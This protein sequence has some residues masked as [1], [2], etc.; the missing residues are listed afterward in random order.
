MSEITVGSVGVEVVPD[1]RQFATRIRAQVL[2]DAARVGTDFGKTLGDAAQ[3]RIADGIQQGVQQGARDAGTQGARAGDDYGGKFATSLKAR[4]DAAL[5]SLPQVKLDADST[6][7]DRAIDGIRAHLAELRDA[8]IGVDISADEAL[9]Q[10]DRLEG[11]LRGLAAE[12]PNIQVRTDTLAAVAE[13]ERVSEDVRRLNGETAHVNVDADTA[14]AEAKMEAFQASSLGASGGVGAL[15]ASALALGP[16]LVPIGAAGAGAMAAIA[17]GAG[18]AAG[19]VGVLVL[20]LAPVIEAVQAVTQAQNQQGS[21]AAS[22]AGKALQL[23]SA[24]DALKTAQRGGRLSRL[25]PPPSR[26]C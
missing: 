5:K 20:A 24:Q 2:P 8:R 7:A 14:A 9:A 10:I 23:A 21:S 17:I 25:T 11:R 19:A 26:R 6:D 12:A 18:A 4:L 1:A 13:L 22:G 15:A 16:A 3:K